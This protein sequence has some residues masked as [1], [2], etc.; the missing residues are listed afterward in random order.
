MKELLV[1]SKAHEEHTMFHIALKP[2]GSLQDI[3][4]VALQFDNTELLHT[5]L[6]TEKLGGQVHDISPKEGYLFLYDNCKEKP[7]P[8]VMIW[9]YE[10]QGAMRYIAN[11]KN[12]DL[13][14]IPLAV[15]EYLR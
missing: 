2:D 7:Y 13:S 3:V 4:C 9:K 12:S 11:M 8:S 5:L 15:K 14:I 1:L 10:F 6:Q